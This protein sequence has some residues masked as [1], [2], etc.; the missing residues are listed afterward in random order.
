MKKYIALAF[1]TLILFCFIY[2]ANAQTFTDIPS[3]NINKDAIEFFKS[4]S[5][6]QGYSDGTYK[7]DNRINRA[8]FVK[9]LA[10]SQTGESEIKSCMEKHSNRANDWDYHPFKDVSFGDWFAG[11][12]CVAKDKGW[13]SGYAD[14][15]FKPG[16]YINFAEASKIITKAL[17]VTPDTT[18]TNNEWFAGFV[19]ALAEKKAI[20]TTIQ[21]F[22][23]DITRGDMVE[24][25]WRVEENITN[26]VSSDYISITQPFPSFKSCEAL[27]EKFK[28]YQS[29]HYG[30][31]R[32]GVVFDMVEEVVPAT[33]ATS[34]MVKSEAPT[35]ISATDYST[36]NIQV[37]GVDEADI[38]K[39]DGKYI[40]MIKGNTVRIIEAYPPSIMKEV[41]TV[42]FDE[43]NFNPSEMFVDGNK[44]VAIGQS[45]NYYG[46]VTPLI[47]PRPWNGSQ[48]KVYILDITDRSNP[49]TERELA[50]DG[51][52]QTS[53]RINNNMY[54][55]LNE[56][57]NVWIMD[58]VKSGEDLLPRMKDGKKDEV[59][60]ARCIDIQYF[61]GFVVPNY[62]I[63]ASIP[64]DDPTS[65]IDR[66]VF[67]GSSDNVYASRTH[68]YVATNRTAYDYYTDWDWHR[69]STRTLVFKFALENGKINFL[70]RGDVPGR[71]LNQFSMD[72]NMDNF[73]IATTIDSWDSEHPS[74]NNVYVMDKDMKVVGKIEEIAPGERIY[75]TR[76]IDDRLYMV[77]FRQVDP[78][79]VISL[80]DPTNP[81]ILGKLKIPGFSNYMHPYDKNHIIGFGKETVD[82]KYGNVIATAFK[83]ALF[84]VS[85]VENP[86]QQ[87]V[88]TIG[89]QGTY[90]EL[91]NNHK[92]LLFDKDKQLLAFPITVNEKVTSEALNCG[93]YRYDTCPSLCMQRCIPTSC[94][95]DA[96][97]V[98]NCTN[99]CGGLGSCTS[100][101]YEQYSTTFSG[102]M[103]YT[104]NLRDG[105]KLRGK[106]T[107]YDDADIL[108]MGDYW[109]Y[110]YDK[111]I[112][113][114]I[115]IGD[116]LYTISQS[117]V[118]ANDLNTVKDVNSV[119]ID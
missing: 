36:T 74:G 29:Y 12:V 14:G 105:F 104:L 15:S 52:Y 11:Y 95:V 112:Q 40:Y 21:F 56:Y 38:I 88:E 89:D 31:M 35:T 37:K 53:R 1:A 79:F 77:T 60:M 9:I 86:K 92:A 111:N 85:D 115:Y 3:T 43:E 91:L 24:I 102:A 117:M 97:G 4:N 101:D 62:L 82:N 46:G 93:K 58:Q 83:M 42:K 19:N 109:P 106:I 73:R 116:Y 39:N 41:S 94:T 33:G 22:D 10:A 25:M 63:V 51:N 16:E 75:S 26:K 103:V 48:T 107:H 13:I 23:K 54:L 34:E 18:G 47:Y 27:Q 61:P 87:F 119:N 65:D 71:I 98:S 68:L 55:V 45:W 90:S 110:N 44:L 32:G 84:D 59:P 70:S 72:A 67:L 7:P 50:F 100:Y 96:Q 76:F 49:K 17:S 8:E 69:D 113:R 28:E 5:V 78:L 118:K 20:P 2:T 57:P 64:L 80:A 81:K 114:I 108:K 6:I 99:D 66:E 30:Y